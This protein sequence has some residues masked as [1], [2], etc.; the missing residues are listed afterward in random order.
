MEV[1]SNCTITLDSDTEWSFLRFALNGVCKVYDA[2]DLEHLYSM[3]ES[4]CEHKQDAYTLNAEQVE[5]LRAILRIFNNDLT[6]SHTIAGRLMNQL[7]EEPVDAPRFREMLVEA[8]LQMYTKDTLP[9]FTGWIDQHHATVREE[10]ADLIRKTGD[11]N[12]LFLHECIIDNPPCS[13]TKRGTE[14][15]AYE[16]IIREV[17]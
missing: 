8:E 12:W 6:T 17:S 11:P 2:C 14:L 4:I 10:L 1:D 9:L 15:E 13:N 5:G 3:R 7:P 16:R